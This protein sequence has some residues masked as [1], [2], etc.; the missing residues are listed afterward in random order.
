MGLEET[1]LVSWRGGLDLSGP[2]STCF[3][4]GGLHFT[5]GSEI[6]SWPMA[7]LYRGRGRCGGGG[8]RAFVIPSGIK[9]FGVCGG[10][11]LHS[12]GKGLGSWSSQAGLGS[13]WLRDSGFILKL[14]T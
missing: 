2:Y 9:C 13:E 4:Q 7:R 12:R 3:A 11:A 5:A 14:C 1:L 6:G 8:P 10:D